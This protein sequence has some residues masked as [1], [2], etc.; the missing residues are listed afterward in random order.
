MRIYLRALEPEDYLLT[1]AW[2]QDEV[3]IEQI[4]SPRFFVSKQREKLWVEGKSTDESKGIFFA[5]CLKENDAMIGYCSIINIDLRHLKADLGGIVIG[6][7]E[8]RGKGYGKE[9]SLLRMQYCFEEYPL[10][11]LCVMALSDNKASN[12][13]LLSLG[14]NLD[15]V[16]RDDVFKCGKFKDVNLYSILRHEYEA[17]YQNTT[18]KD[19]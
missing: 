19:I 8:L 17:R 15:G 14:F 4:V 2:R 10:N 13:M 6:I 12:R 3:V 9:A 7:P 1:H 5:I 18:K 11:K 16:L